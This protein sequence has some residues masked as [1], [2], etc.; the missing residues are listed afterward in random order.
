MENKNKNK[1]Y[2]IK[3]EIARFLGKEMGRSIFLGKA[4]VYKIENEQK[5][6]IKKDIDILLKLIEN[7]IDDNEEKE[8]IHNEIAISSE[9]DN[10]SNILK[11]IDIVNINN[12]NFIAYEYYNGG[13]LREYLDFFQ[14]FEEN[15][16]QAIMMQLVNALVELS[17]KNI[18]H[19]DIKPEYILLNFNDISEEEIS[20]IREIIENN[21]KEKYQNISNSIN[22]NCFNNFNNQFVPIN[23]FQNNN[24]YNNL[25]FND[26]MMNQNNNINMMNMNGNNFYNN[27]MNQNN[28]VNMMNMN[29]NN[30]YN[31]MMNQNNNINMMNMNGNIINKI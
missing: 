27:M 11:V 19:H 29:G 8:I 30:F 28:N 22:P 10:N 25:N 20:K 24:L 1:F 21:K 3:K 16:I 5:T 9:L 18:V 6:Y 12:Q 31:N 23:I 17:K 2:E 4:D 13:N 14:K 15:H 7:S 26:N